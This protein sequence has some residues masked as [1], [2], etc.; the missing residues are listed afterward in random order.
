MKTLSKKRI[1]GNTFEAMAAR[2]CGCPCVC[3]TGQDLEVY[4][5]QS[6]YKEVAR[7]Q[8]L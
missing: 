8:G 1:K 2:K 6:I 3:A 5:R 7:R 4:N